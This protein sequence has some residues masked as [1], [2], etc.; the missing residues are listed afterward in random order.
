MLDTLEEWLSLIIGF[1]LVGFVFLVI[2]LIFRSPTLWLFLGILTVIL[3]FFPILRSFLAM[4]SVR[5]SRQGPGY[6]R[7]EYRKQRKSADAQSK[8][9]STQD[10]LIVLANKQKGQLM[11]EHIQKQW[12]SEVS[13]PS[14]DDSEGRTFTPPSGLPTD[15]FLH[16]FWE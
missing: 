4:R 6:Q 5:R 2:A 14:P 7:E 1:L 15:F 13:K 8:P 12:T 3:F 11:P 16:D 9:A 10:Q